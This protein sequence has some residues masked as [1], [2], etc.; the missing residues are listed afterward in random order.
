MII[1][2]HFKGI[3]LIFHAAQLSFHGYPYPIYQDPWA[4]PILTE[5]GRKGS[6]S[7]DNSDSWKHMVAPG[8]RLVEK[9]CKYYKEQGVQQ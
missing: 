5:G 8:H 3:L 2:F 1:G 4:C 6:S 9:N 7:S